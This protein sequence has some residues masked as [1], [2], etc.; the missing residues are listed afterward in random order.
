MVAK[1]G[2]RAMRMPEPFAP[3]S[4]QADNAAPLAAL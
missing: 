2:I 4:K 3:A 1:Q